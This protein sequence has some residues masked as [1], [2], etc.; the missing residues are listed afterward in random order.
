MSTLAWFGGLAVTL[1]SCLASLHVPGS[2]V[3]KVTSDTVCGVTAASRAHGTVACIS[4]RC[5]SSCSSSLLSHGDQRT[6][7][8]VAASWQDLIAGNGGAA[9][10]SLDANVI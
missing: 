9:L 6:L 3:I 7:I 5:V 1:W 4:E 10:A 2:H 8:V